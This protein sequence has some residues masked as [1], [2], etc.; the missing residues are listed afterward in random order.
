MLAR[1]CPATSTHCRWCAIVCN[2][3]SVPTAYGHQ[4]VLVRGYVHEVVISCGDGD[5]RASS[6]QLTN[7]KTL[8]SIRLHYLELIEQKTNALDQAAPLSRLDVTARVRDALRRLLEARMGKKGKREFVQVL[9]LM[10]GVVKV[11]MMSPA[12]FAMPLNT[13]RLALT[14]SNISCSAAS[15]GARHGSI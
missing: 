12:G 13:V 14:P 10:E 11:S 2:D 5:H 3:Y 9:R 1:R 7:V 15:S 8:S 6:A 4:K